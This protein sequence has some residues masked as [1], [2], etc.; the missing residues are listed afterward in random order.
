M[1]VDLGGQQALV[2]GGSSGIGAAI[3]QELANR[4][5]NVLISGR[6]SSRLKATAKKISGSWIAADLAMDEDLERVVQEAGPLDLLV[7]SAAVFHL[8]PLELAPV[9]ELDAT[10][11]LNI[12][13]PYLLTQ[14]LLPG[15]LDRRGQIAFINSSAARKTIPNAGPYAASKAA[16]KALAD[17]LRAE[18][19]PRGVRVLSVFPGR[20]A[21][22]MQKQVRLLEGDLPYQSER[23]LQPEDVA[24][25][26]VEALTLPL[27]AELTELDIRPMQG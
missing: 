15:L 11:R 7:H 12:R 21:T 27:S 16:L 9:E 25:A 14:K 19:N 4:G 22:A 26:V 24:L 23:Y 13:A 5:M 8:G 20:V 2:T 18:I 17:S 1:R 6:D 10:Y 3:A